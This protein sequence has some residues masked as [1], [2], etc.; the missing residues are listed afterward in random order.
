M[1]LS[2]TP[3]EARVILAGR[4]DGRWCV[5]DLRPGGRPGGMGV[6]VEVG[7]GVRVRV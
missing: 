6:G 3:R 7:V 4:R 1:S 2:A 5:A